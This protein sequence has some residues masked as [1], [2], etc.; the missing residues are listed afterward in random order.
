MKTDAEGLA[1]RPVVDAG[2]DLVGV[3]ALQQL[4]DAAGELDDVDAARDLALRVREHLAV[5]GGDHRRE[6]VAVFVH[7]AEELV[8]HA[9]TA[10]GRGV[11]PL[12]ERVLRGGHGGRHLVRVG[13][14]HLAGHAAGGRVVDGL[15]AAAGAGGLAAAHVVADGV[16]GGE[17]FDGAHGVV[18]VV[19]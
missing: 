13:Q 6:R 19:C 5:F 17:G 11:G 3:V 12:R 8:Q 7:Q 9:G 18:P 16:G 2:A 14:R 4:G 1:H 10:D 15:A